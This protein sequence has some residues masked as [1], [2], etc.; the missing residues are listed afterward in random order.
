MIPSSKREIMIR[1]QS[2]TDNPSSAGGLSRT[3]KRNG[4]MS[5]ARE[6]LGAACIDTERKREPT[7]GEL[8]RT[9]FS[10]P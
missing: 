8:C 1:S 4:S 3:L 5:G 10:N 7:I 2:S 9:S 6:R